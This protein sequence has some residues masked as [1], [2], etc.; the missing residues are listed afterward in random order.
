MTI[1]NLEKRLEIKRAMNLE[2]TIQ[3]IEYLLQEME[4]K[5]YD[6]TNYSSHMVYGEKMYKET[7]IIEKEVPSFID[8]QTETK[9]ILQGMEQQ[10]TALETFLQT[11]AINERNFLIKKYTSNCELNAS[12]LSKLEERTLT[13]IAVVEHNLLPRRPPNNKKVSV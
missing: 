4:Q 2:Y 12:R 8:N 9:I 10:Q 1:N 5:F 13:A 6:N 7:F 3:E 11:L